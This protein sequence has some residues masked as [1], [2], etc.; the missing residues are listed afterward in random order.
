MYRV[1]VPGED[2]IFTVV[3]PTIHERE[4][5]PVGEGPQ[6]QFTLYEDEDRINRAHN[7]L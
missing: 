6:Q 2:R 1:F 3:R 4:V 7:L 5:Y